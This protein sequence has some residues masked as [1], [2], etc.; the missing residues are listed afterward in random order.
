MSEVLYLKA[1]D[2]TALMNA[3]EQAG[4]IEKSYDP[5]DPNNY[6]P[7]GLEEWDGPTGVYHWNHNEAY[8][9]DII[10]VMFVETGELTQTF[11]GFDMPTFAAVEGYHANLRGV[12]TDE[13]KAALPTIDAPATP[14]RVF[15][16]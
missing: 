11:D 2:E 5:D 13:Q 4:I 12:F 3:L 1:T 6:R 7:D 15:G 14:E 16:G 10:G 8:D 9:V